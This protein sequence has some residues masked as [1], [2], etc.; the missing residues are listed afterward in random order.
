M[1]PHLNHIRVDDVRL[2]V[3]LG[4]YRGTHL[5]SK[6]E[7]KSW[8]KQF[9]TKTRRENDIQTSE[10]PG[11]DIANIFTTKGKIRG[12]TGSE[13][14]SEAPPACGPRLGVVWCLRAPSPSHFR[15]VFSYIY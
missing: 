1:H 10:D 15:L 8:Q 12:E 2:G 9:E 6:S 3:V 14:S 13:R 4:R 5:G 11:D 7:D